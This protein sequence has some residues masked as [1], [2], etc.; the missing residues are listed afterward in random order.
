MKEEFETIIQNKNRRVE[1]KFIVVKGHID[2]PTLIGRDTL[3]ELGMMVVEP[4]GNLKETN[5]LRI[6]QISGMNETKS[7][8][9]LIREY[10][11]VF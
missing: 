3:I 9:E 7:T 5:E 8:K 6:K 1:T 2:N 4:N 11:N 10:N